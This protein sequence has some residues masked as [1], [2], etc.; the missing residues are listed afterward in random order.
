MAPPC[1]SGDAGLDGLR[2]EVVTP[3]VHRIGAGRLT[4]PRP[5]TQEPVGMIIDGRV[6]VA[7]PPE[8][9]FEVLVDPATWFEIDPTL[10]DV[11]PRER[12][13]LGSTGTMRN[14]RGPG[15]VATVTW[16]TTEYVAGRRL[17]QHLRGFGYELTESIDLLPVASGTQMTVVDTLTPTSIVGRVMVAVSRGI[18]ERDLRSRFARLQA[19]LEVEPVNI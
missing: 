19:L 11:T 8:R 6:T 17:S 12:V 5:L 2:D 7:T 16:T 15:M 18:M 1:R 13:V 14:R 10:I 3:A 4:V 9:V